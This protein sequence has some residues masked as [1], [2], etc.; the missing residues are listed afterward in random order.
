MNKMKK[1]IGFV[2]IIFILIG[3]YFFHRFNSL[4][5][6]LILAN[7]NHP[8]FVKFDSVNINGKCIDISFKEYATPK[9][10]YDIIMDIENNCI[11]TINKINSY[12]DYTVKV[13]IS[14]SAFPEYSIFYDENM[15]E[16]ILSISPP[17]KRD[18]STFTRLLR[19]HKNV[20]DIIINNY[21][22]LSSEECC[23]IDNYNEFENL[24]KIQF[25]KK[26][27]DEIIKYLREQVPQCKIEY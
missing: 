12:N 3:C 26:P 25:V 14:D 2:I 11:N 6:R 24:E 16:K 4:E 19:Q 23:K 18:L 13:S 7:I 27:S 21:H 10:R 8:F 17:D 9:K 20:K 15:K 22:V 5:R 1:K